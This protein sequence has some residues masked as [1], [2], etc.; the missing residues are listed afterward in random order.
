VDCT[1]DVNCVSVM[2]SSSFVIVGCNETDALY[3]D[4]SSSNLQ[5]NWLLI[6]MVSLSSLVFVLL[7]IPTIRYARAYF[8]PQTMNLSVS[9]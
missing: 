4:N 6:S 9:P 3:T 7:M 8:C 5:V 1:G 2:N